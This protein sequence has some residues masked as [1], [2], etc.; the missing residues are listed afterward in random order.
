MLALF[1][2]QVQDSR[3]GRDLRTYLANR[4]DANTPYRNLVLADANQVPHGILD[5]KAKLNLLIFWASWCGPCRQ[6]IPALKQVY[7]AFHGRGL[8]MAGISID[9]APRRWQHALAEEQMGWQQFILPQSQALRIKQQFNLSGV[10]L[11]ILT[12]SLGNEIMQEIGFGE[13]SL[14]ALNEAIAARL[15]Q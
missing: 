4:T 1:Q 13:Q 2:Q 15:R 12:D 5:P 6:E 8:H 9:E 14:A 11:V 3:V 7:R 10:P